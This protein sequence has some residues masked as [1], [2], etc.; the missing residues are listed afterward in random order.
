MPQ[1]TLPAD[2]TFLQILQERRDQLQ[3]VI[4]QTCR[5]RH[6]VRAVGSRPISMEPDDIDRL[7]Y[8][9]RRLNCT[10]MNGIG[11]ALQNIFVAEKT[12]ANEPTPAALHVASCALLS[13][14]DLPRVQ[15]STS[16]EFL[17][18]RLEPTAYWEKSTWLIPIHRPGQEHWVFVAADVRNL[19]LYF[20][21]SLG[22]R[23]HWNSDLHV[24]P[25]FPS[26]RRQSF[27]SI[28]T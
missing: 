25:D 18:S 13:T 2:S 4:D 23:E 24:R 1:S 17:W 6:T 26:D 8:P 10:I 5:F 28:R 9:A 12:R 7:R 11:A 15:G 22:A 21:D 27:T 3:L 14:H 20:F 16:D 19:R